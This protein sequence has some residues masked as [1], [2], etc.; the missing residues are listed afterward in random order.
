MNLLGIYSRAA[1]WNEARYDRVYNHDFSMAL[2]REEHKEY[3]DAISDVKGLD[4]LCDIIFV[5][6]GVLW[7][8]DLEP[9]VFEEDVEEAYKHVSKLM[10]TNTLMPIYLISAV[11]DCC[12]HDS[13]YPVSLAMH[14]IISLAMVQMS[15]FGFDEVK[16][17]VAVL[18]VCD[19]NDSKSV[20]KAAANVKANIDKGKDF[21]CPEPR[22]Q[23]LL[24]NEG[25]R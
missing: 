11:I 6:M 10:E 15:I 9:E 4:A 25:H 3:L 22:L 24:N 8:L 23:E 17:C 12:D 19:S 20:Q 7:K 1:A 13:D 2:L 14:V 16:K 5:A 21:I 18:V